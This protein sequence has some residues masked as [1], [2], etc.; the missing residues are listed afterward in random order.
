MRETSRAT[1]C[2]RHVEHFESRGWG[3]VAAE[4][5]FSRSHLG[6]AVASGGPGVDAAVRSQQERVRRS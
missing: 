1:R 4:C 5:F 3:L 2:C 6:V